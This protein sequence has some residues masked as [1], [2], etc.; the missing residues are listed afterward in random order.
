MNE[1]EEE[2]VIINIEK[3]WK[4]KAIIFILFIILFSIITFFITGDRNQYYPIIPFIIYAIFYC[5]LGI[6]PSIIILFFRWLLKRK[7]SFSSFFTIALI[8]LIILGFLAIQGAYYSATHP[9]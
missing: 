1:I 2:S 7:I 6:I 5:L 3:K 9:L 8:F 4:L